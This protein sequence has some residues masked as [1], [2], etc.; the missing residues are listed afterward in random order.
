M[1]GI[2]KWYNRKKGFGFIKGTDE[3]D[4]FVHHTSLGDTFLRDD[5]KVSFDAADTD[6]GKQAQNVKLL[7]K[8]SDRTDVP[9]TEAPAKA[10]EA[11]PV[12]EAEEDDE[13]S[14]DF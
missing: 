6:K 7:E 4:Y 3:V 10:N 8:G 13:I 9:K 11:V 1:E 14:E 5:D 2:V 12:E